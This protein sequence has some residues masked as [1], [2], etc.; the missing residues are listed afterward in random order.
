MSMTT[1]DPPIITDINN[2]LMTPEQKAAEYELCAVSKYYFLTRHCFTLDSDA[3][4]GE[5][6]I[7]LMPHSTKKERRHLK[8]LIDI[9]DSEDDAWIK[10]SRQVMASWVFMACQ[11]HDISFT[12][13]MT[14]L[15]LSEKGEYVDDGT[16]ESLHGKIKFMWEALPPYLKMPI[17]FRNHPV[18]LISNP[19][20]KSFIRGMATTEN[21]SRSGN[22]KKAL[23]D[24]AGFIPY[25]EMI[26]SA[27]RFACKRGLK[28]LSTPP[29]KKKCMYNRVGNLLPVEQRHFIHWQEFR[30]QAWADRIC[31]TLTKEQIDR[32]L[33]LKDTDDGQVL[34]W[35]AFNYP[36]HVRKD[37]YQK[38]AAVK[39]TMDFGYNDATAAKFLQD[40]AGE[41]HIVRDYSGRFMLPHQHA[42]GMLKILIELQKA[43]PEA[44]KYFELC[45]KIRDMEL[46]ISQQRYYKI[47]ME[48]REQ[49]DNAKES[50]NLIDKLTKEVE[51]IRQE[52]EKALSTHTRPTFEKIEFYGDPACR[53]TM[54]TTGKT[55]SDEYAVFGINIRT[56]PQAN[57][58]FGIRQVQIRFEKNKMF[59]DE[60]CTMT[61]D[62]LNNYQYP[63][64][65][66]GKKKEGE[67]PV[68][69]EYSHGASALRYYCEYKPF[70]DVPRKAAPKWQARGGYGKHN[71]K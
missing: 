53:A 37:L 57:V 63:T 35:P 22:F 43:G 17:V 20:T 48:K 15:N 5:E 44:L 62:E 13:G 19:V 21:A 45:D 47:D 34:V 3:P 29:K 41:V 64:D 30:D 65:G 4:A 10:K 50:Q 55:I 59:I 31:A 49:A 54:Q 26:Y 6:S 42:R 66:N 52:A 11:L 27:A 69:D 32:E 39:I 9:W 18:M 61:I 56:M 16:V 51:N 2:P 24:E 71:R 8:R 36:I 46:Q 40:I 68:H 33:E 14:I 23:I 1:Q 28:L 25:G 60:L 7:K 67:K 70:D 38:A 12:E 58:E